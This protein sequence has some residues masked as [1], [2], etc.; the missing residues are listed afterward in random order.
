MSILDTFSIVFDSNSA[1]VKQGLDQVT[2]GSKQAQAEINATG[3]AGVRLGHSIVESND[4]ASHSFDILREHADHVA[5]RLIEH[6][7]EVAAAFKALFEVEKLIDNFFEQA[8]SSEKLGFLAKQLGVNIEELDA[9]GEAV[10]R[11][12]GTAEGFQSSIENLNFQ[13]T[14]ISVTG[15]SRSL[16]F[17]Q[18]LGIDATHAKNAFELLPQLAEKFAKMD[19]MKSSAFGRAIGL[20]VGTVRLLQQGGEELNKTIEHMKRLG[21]IT[22]ENSKIAHEFE[23]QWLDVSQLLRNFVLDSNNGIL[24]LL[25]ELLHAVEIFVEFLR[26]HKDV[27]VGFFI[28]IGAAVAALMYQFGVLDILASPWLLMAAAVLTVIAAIALLY[29]DLRVFFRGGKSLT[30]EFVEYFKE[31]FGQAFE[32]LA[33]NLRDVWKNSG[34]IIRTEIEHIKQAWENFTTG[35]ADQF[36]TVVNLITTLWAKVIDVLNNG[37]ILNLI[38]TFDDLGKT[39][40]R[41]GNEI[42]DIFKK[43]W[44]E[45]GWIVDR[46]AGALPG[47]GGGAGGIGHGGRHVEQEMPGSI[48]G[49]A[50]VPGASPLTDPLGAILSAPGVQGSASPSGTVGAPALPGV[51]PTQVANDIAAGQNVLAATNSPLLAQTTSSIATGAN[52]NVQIHNDNH[53]GTISV[54]GSSDPSETASKIKTILQEHYDSV[55]PNYA[56]GIAQ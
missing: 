47:M 24:P 37:S 35:A 48:P 13:L 21:T 28:A 52:T 5:E 49:S 25:T 38:N 56:N 11:Q 14:R 3:Q 10:K 41:I 12:G 4:K 16:K 18:Q 29:D 54:T 44:S 6:A 1:A 33:E 53:I 36:R 19:P 7:L 39:V 27:V 34:E 17:F 26:D 55:I 43:I 50:P 30:G 45:V 2:Q 8:E 40:I 15:H 32:H 23:D 20:D 22:E 42:I 9:W 31:T 51:M 46:I